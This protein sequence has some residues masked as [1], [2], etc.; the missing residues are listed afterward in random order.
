MTGA[1]YITANDTISRQWLK[2]IERTLQLLD[3]IIILQITAHGA[4][5]RLY[6]C[7]VWRR[8]VHEIFTQ[9]VNTHFRVGIGPNE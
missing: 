4:Y 2:R 5:E 7:I 3:I 9:Q 6:L 8:Y 1:F